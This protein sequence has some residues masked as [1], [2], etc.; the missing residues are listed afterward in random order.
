MAWRCWRRSSAI[1]APF[2]PASARRLVTVMSSCASPS[3]IMCGM[4]GWKTAPAGGRWCRALERRHEQ[5]L[6][7]YLA[8]DATISY[9]LEPDPILRSGEAQFLFGRA[10]HVAAESDLPLLRIQ[11]AADGPGDWRE[12][13]L[14]YP[15]QR[16]TLI[17]GDRRAS[18]VA[19]IGWPFLSGES[20]LLVLRP[21][22]PPLV[23]MGVEPPDSVTLTPDGEGGFALRDR[24][25]RGLRLRVVAL[26]AQDRVLTR[27][28]WAVR[29]PNR[30][31]FRRLLR[32]QCCWPKMPTPG[33]TN[34]IR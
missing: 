21:G 15:G 24:R 12:V 8:D 18:S 29:S 20:A 27:S 3:A 9:R 28:D 7:R 2:A 25:G 19:V 16:L 4:T 30:V 1:P 11:T 22:P 17:N 26:T 5:E 33:W 13:G 14:I 31:A 34:L 32:R 10:I 6:G 23:D